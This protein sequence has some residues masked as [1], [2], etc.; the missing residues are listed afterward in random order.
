MD[1]QHVRA[2]DDGTRVVATPE[3]I[4]TTRRIL[5]EIREEENEDERKDAT[6][7]THPPT[8]TSSNPLLPPGWKAYV[9]CTAAVVLRH[10]GVAT[11]LAERRV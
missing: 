2:S 7:K 10:V 3:D 9:T 8:T 4:R 1:G 6:E 11:T 5:K